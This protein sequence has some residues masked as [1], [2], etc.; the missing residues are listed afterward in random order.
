MEELRGSELKI[1][2]DKILDLISQIKRRD[3]ILEPILMEK[4]RMEIEKK[5]NENIFQ[6]NL[7]EWI[8]KVETKERV[9]NAVK[10]EFEGN[11]HSFILLFHIEFPN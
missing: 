4:E 9:T 10:R 6:E 8:G 7:N 3:R 11:N 1:A 2:H 5:A